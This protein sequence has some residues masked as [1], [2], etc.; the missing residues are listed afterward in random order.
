MEENSKEKGEELE[1]LL[2]EV[3][4]LDA[5]KPPE[6]EPKDPHERDALRKQK[7]NAIEKLREEIRK[8]KRR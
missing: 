6:F 1:K 7:T 5:Q 4:K 8:M 3:E 2:K